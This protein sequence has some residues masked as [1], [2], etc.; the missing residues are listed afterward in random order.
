MGILTW[1]IIGLVLGFI[2]S[3]I[4]GRHNTIAN[5]AVGLV[6]ACVSGWIA[7]LFGLGAIAT[8]NIWNALIALAGAAVLLVLF[9]LVKRGEAA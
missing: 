6:G 1:A 5:L 2:F 3:V 8:F 9:R 4:A 7:T